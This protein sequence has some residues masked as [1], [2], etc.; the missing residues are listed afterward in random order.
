MEQLLRKGYV[1]K[2]WIVSVKEL[3]NLSY[4][5]NE[6]KWLNIA[7]YTTMN[8]H[9]FNNILCVDSNTSSASYVLL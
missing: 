2:T 6:D 5:K 4:V 7:K 1:F 9:L 8:I 3:K